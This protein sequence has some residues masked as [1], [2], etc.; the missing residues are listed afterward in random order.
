M[1][2]FCQVGRIPGSTS[3]VIL[4]QTIKIVF[5]QSAYTPV[6]I[7]C[8]GG[9]SFMLTFFWKSYVFMWNSYKHV[10]HQVASFPVRSV[11]TITITL[12]KGPKPARPGPFTWLMSNFPNALWTEATLCASDNQISNYFCN[13]FWSAAN[14]YQ[15]VCMISHW[16]RQY[17]YYKTETLSC[18]TQLRTE[19]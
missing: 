14:D 8:R 5:I 11:W 3:L 18:T 10:Y 12:S 2:W 7:I 17:K 1:T 13:D 9:V 19:K 4:C 6:T 15:A 16:R